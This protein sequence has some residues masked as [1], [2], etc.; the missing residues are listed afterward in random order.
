MIGGSA[1]GPGYTLTD[2]EADRIT[3]VTLRLQ[4][5]PTGAAANRAPDLLIRDLSLDGQR[6]GRL[7]IQTT[8]IVQVEGALLV[9]GVQATGGVDIRADERLQLVNP[10]GSI[11]VR[12]ASGL[13]GGTVNF[14]S[15]NIW[16]ASQA[17]LDQLLADFN[18]AGRDDALTANSGPTS[19]AAIS[20]RTM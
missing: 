9:T 20:K 13:P 17:L 5:S 6:I 10:A 1:Q 2:A 14:T 12:E 7:D 11:R 4:A 19:R 16:S 8:R 18:F 3:A 15:N